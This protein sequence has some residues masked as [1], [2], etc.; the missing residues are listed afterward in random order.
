MNPNSKG[1]AQ[2]PAAPS[3]SPSAE[4]AAV[5]PMSRLL[6]M[7]SA[8]AQGEQATTENSPAAAAKAAPAGGEAPADAATG[9]EEAGDPADAGQAD[10]SQS[11]PDETEEEREAREAAEAEASGGAP[12]G[13]LPAELAE[14]PEDVREQLLAMAKEVADGSINFGDLK[15]GHKLAARH[16]EEVEQLRQENES[17]K[18]KLEAG[19][20]TAP[21]GEAGLY[22][23]VD[24]VVK[25]EQ[26]LQKVLDWCED[27]PEGGEFNGQEFTAAE[28]KDARRKARDE[29]KYALPGRKEQLQQQAQQQ[30]QFTKAQQQA[31]GEV[32]KNFPALKDPDNTETQA[33]NKMLHEVPMLK[34]MFISPELAALT[35][36]R[37]EQAL[38]A[39]LAK[40]GVQSPKSKV[41]SPR[42]GAV[43]TGRPSGGGG[44]A[45]PARTGAGP[46][47]AKAKERIASERSVGALADL[48]GAMEPGSK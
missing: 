41:Q 3:G 15:R 34:T 35:W 26:Q 32:L 9:E 6:Q 33:V 39:D 16:A 2:S 18:Q 8:M 7:Q 5:D 14:L 13:A 36:L 24:D 4:A 40:R 42:P 25:R 31:R 45:A 46:T 11:N 38:R 22:K 30:A 19:T 20:T 21:G 48:I 17:L 10:L 37:G 44:T 27:N 23:T 29:I 1:S 12:E 28:V 47:V 43:K